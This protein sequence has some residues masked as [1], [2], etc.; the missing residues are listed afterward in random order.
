MYLTIKNKND[1]FVF[2]KG[3]KT[4]KMTRKNGECH[5]Q[6]DI[7]FDDAFGPR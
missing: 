4:K 6:Y 1:S 7:Y 3:L 5:G 2:E